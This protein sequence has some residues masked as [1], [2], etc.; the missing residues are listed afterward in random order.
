MK[1][2]R[3]AQWSHFLK[4]NQACNNLTW[5]DTGKHWYSFED[6]VPNNCK[7]VL[8][9]FKK[10]SGVGDLEVYPDD[11]PTLFKTHGFYSSQ[12]IV[13][14]VSRQMRFR[15]T[16]ANTVF[17]VSLHGLWIQVNNVKP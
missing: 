4:A 15:L 3:R 10:V 8:V 1:A 9:C 6:E 12:I 11:G 2:D 7:A 13:G 16:S 5:N 17:S 14:L